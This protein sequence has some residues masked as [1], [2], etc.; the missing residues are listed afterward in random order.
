MN[1]RPALPKNG[2]T[3]RLVNGPGDV[4]AP[5]FGVVLKVHDAELVDVQITVPGHQIA[6]ERLV[7]WFANQ[8]Q[9]NAYAQAHPGALCVHP[10]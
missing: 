3:V 7:P 10:Q 5:G 6:R 8:A 2:S 1:T 4:A 9:A